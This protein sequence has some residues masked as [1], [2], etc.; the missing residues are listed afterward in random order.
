MAD[1]TASNAA[2]FLE[3]AAM[4]TI[5][6]AHRAQRALAAA[7]AKHQA[8]APDAA[9]ELLAT[10]RAGPLDE[11]GR[12]Q[13]ELLDA[14]IAFAVRRGRD[15][16]P[17]LLRA[18]QQLEPGV[19]IGRHQQLGL[20]PDR[21]PRRARLHPLRAHVDRVDAVL[22][23]HVVEHDPLALRRHEQHESAARTL[24]ARHM[25]RHAADDLSRHG[26]TSAHRRRDRFE[27]AVE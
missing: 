1:A 25:K 14:Q 7:Q 18:A 11:L 16:P 15:A 17:L 19:H 3:R 24:R 22:R 9:L 26:P 10:A 12:A 4:L 2:A 6:P 27:S 23:Q 8:G 5:E 13:I 21:Q 20:L